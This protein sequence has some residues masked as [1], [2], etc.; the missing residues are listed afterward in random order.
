[1]VKRISFQHVCMRLV[2]SYQ[3]IVVRDDIETTYPLKTFSFTNK[4]ACNIAAPRRSNYLL[5][6]RNRD[7]LF[8][9]TL[10]FALLLAN[11]VF[12]WFSAFPHILSVFPNFHSFNA[13]CSSIA[14]KPHIHKHDLSWGLSTSFFALSITTRLYFYLRPTQAR[15][16][17]ILT[18]S[19]RTINSFFALYARS[20]S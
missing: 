12:Q 14:S 19:S 18:V 8:L 15:L 3:I 4:L 17:V 16:T 7:L 10:L 2:L 1:M 11:L 13:S 9:S 20:V 6:S 5:E